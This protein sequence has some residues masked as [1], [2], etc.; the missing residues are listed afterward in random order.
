M[1]GICENKCWKLWAFDHFINCS[2]SINMD[3]LASTN[4]A[5]VDTESITLDLVK[6]GVKYSNKVANTNIDL[7]I[8]R[9]L[10]NAMFIPNRKACKAASVPIDLHFRH[11]VTCQSRDMNN[12][13]SDKIVYFSSCCANLFWT[14]SRQIKYV[15]IWKKYCSSAFTSDSR[16]YAIFLN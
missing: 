6:R 7:L 13:T 15:I 16:M 8:Y 4:I 2:S 11:H 14:N 9:S 1:A 3:E 12:T 10:W 5:Q